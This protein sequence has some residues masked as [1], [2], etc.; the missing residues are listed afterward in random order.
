M[1]TTGFQSARAVTVSAGT[2]LVDLGTA[3]NTVSYSVQ[4]NPTNAADPQLMRCTAGACAAV[5]DQVIG[6]KIGAALWDNKQVNGAELVN[7]FFNAANYCNDY[8]AD[9]S[10]SPPPANDPYD[11]SLVRAV[12]ISMIARTPPKTDQSL[13]SFQ[14]GFDNGPYL[15]QQSAVVV[16]LRNMSNNEFDN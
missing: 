16:D 12:R 4:P 9:C 8:A 2:Y 10:V 6:F 11:F 1:G 5:V 7:Y 15:V 13:F 3:A 14:N